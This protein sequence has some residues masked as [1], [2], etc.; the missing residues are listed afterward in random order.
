M[1]D[2]VDMASS[3][4]RTLAKLLEQDSGNLRLLADAAEAAFAEA[5]F[6]AAQRL[7]DRQ[8]ALA[9]LSPQSQH[10]AGLVAM[11]QLDW[12]H[13]V[14][15][16]RALLDAGSDAPP[17]RYNLAWSL[18]M[19]KRFEDALAA[20]DDATSAAIPQAAQLEVQLRHQLGEL[21]EALDRA[22]TLIV[23]HPDHS[24]LNAAV[25]TLAI[26]MEDVALAQHTAEKG[27]G[28]PDALTTLGTLALEADDPAAA[29]GMFEAALARAPDAPRAWIGRGLTR[30][31]G[32]D[33]AAAATDLDR[34]A[35]LFGV[36]LGSWIAA[37]WA[38]LLAGDRPAARARF[39]KAA[40]LDDRFGEAQGSLAVLDLLEG[41]T[42]G[43]RRRAD[44]A[45]RLDPD[46]F[47]AAF[48]AMLFAVGEGKTDVATRIFETALRTP[49]DDKGKTLAQTLVRLGAH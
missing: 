4:Y 15:V 11:Q 49:I 18:A 12:E 10:L 3:R 35:E 19:T 16:Y 7:I 32:D 17:I 48:A 6:D 44:I 2:Q 46:S 40:T 33:K 29:A 47:S 45:R 31:L 25:S 5:Q 1:K 9:P 38:H 20:I 26:D 36:H 13:A 23:L 34:G 24:G 30:L 28:H 14:T 39:D 42:E 37:G 21:E 22:R 41:D 8:A 43:A 27:G